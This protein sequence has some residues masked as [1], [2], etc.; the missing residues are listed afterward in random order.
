MAK[1]IPKDHDRYTYSRSFFPLNL[2]REFFMARRRRLP[3]SVSEPVVNSATSD[4]E[5]MY[6]RKLFE[7]SILK[8]NQS[9]VAVTNKSSSFSPSFTARTNTVHASSERRRGLMAKFH[10]ADF[11]ETSPNG[12]VGVMEFRLYR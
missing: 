12:K 3:C 7:L 1:K 9:S 8:P 5:A 2:H 11:P 10:Y 4:T 6:L